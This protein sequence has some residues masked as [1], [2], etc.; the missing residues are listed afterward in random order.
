M[1]A[2]E[3]YLLQRNGAGTDT[4]RRVLVP[5]TG[6]QIVLI[7][8]GNISLL[9]FL[10]ANNKIP[11]SLLNDDAVSR[12]VIVPD[13][14]ARLALTTAQVQLGDVVWQDD[15]SQEYFVVDVSELDSA[16]GY[17]TR[18]TSVGSIPWANVT[19]KP[20]NLAR[21]VTVP[22]TS[23]SSGTWGDFACDDDNL[24]VYVGDETTHKWLQFLGNTF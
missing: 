1:A 21:R 7:D 17:K 14:A 18:S 8:N 4:M 3:L 12:V 5:G 20:T 19:G 23:T 2:N 16:A 22:S 9:N 13:Q 11:T 15:S 6:K 24:Y 10:D